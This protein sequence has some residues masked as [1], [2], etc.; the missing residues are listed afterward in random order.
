[1]GLSDTIHDNIYHFLD[2][3][4]NYD[5]YSDAEYEILQIIK[6]HLKMMNRLD[7]FTYSQIYSEEFWDKK[8]VELFNDY[9][10]NE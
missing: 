8:A 5:Y 6:I 3:I 7:S 1:M 2:E 4:T 9:V 10:R